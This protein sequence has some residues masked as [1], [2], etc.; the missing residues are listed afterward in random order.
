[1]PVFDWS[2]VG[3][4]SVKMEAVDHGDCPI[5]FQNVL[6][7]P[8]GSG[9]RGDRCMVPY[10]LLSHDRHMTPQII[11]TQCNF[12]SPWHIL[13]GVQQTTSLLVNA[14]VSTNCI[15]AMVC[16]RHSMIFLTEIYL[17]WSFCLKYA[18]LHPRASVH[19]K[20]HV[21]NFEVDF[22]ICT[23]KCTQEFW[24]GLLVCKI[25]MIQNVVYSKTG[26]FYLL[27][28]TSNVGFARAVLMLH[29]FLGCSPADSIQ[30]TD[31]KWRRITFW[32]CPLIPIKS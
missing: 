5:C 10:I 24:V 27:C 2:V 23:L 13:I 14:D 17:L 11:I 9:N 4:H 22:K 21:N 7:A 19:H 31:Y 20:I 32:Y 12:L 28:G 6:L 1:M 3:H 26:V 30:P 25:N 15:V 16:E 29:T 18:Y 8:S